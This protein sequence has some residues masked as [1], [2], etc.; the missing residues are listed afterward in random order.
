V[1][2][3]L[4]DA[5]KTA[6]LWCG[7]ADIAAYLQVQQRKQGD[8]SL[9][10]IRSRVYPICDLVQALSSPEYGGSGGPMCVNADQVRQMFAKFK[11]KL[12]PAAVRFAVHLANTPDSGSLRTL[13]QIV[14]FS[15]L[16]AQAAKRNSIDVDLLKGAMARGLT[17]DRAEM[18]LS[19]MHET[20]SRI[21]MAATA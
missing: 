15:I 5:T 11:L 1:L 7:T 17:N 16:L 12:T 6:Q 21:R 8:E 2:T 19:R 3:D 13:K 10:Q 9:A 14:K 20:E 4:H 18:L